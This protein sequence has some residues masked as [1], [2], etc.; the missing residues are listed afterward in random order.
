MKQ[1]LY[2]LEALPKKLVDCS[3]LDWA[4]GEYTFK[5]PASK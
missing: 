2:V 1:P 5:N 4:N 3:L